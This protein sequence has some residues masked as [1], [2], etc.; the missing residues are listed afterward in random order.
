[1]RW[2]GR[3]AKFQTG[4][5][6]LTSAQVHALY[7]GFTVDWNLN[8]NI[9]TNIATDEAEKDITYTFNWDNKLREAEWPTGNSIEIK[10]D[11]LGNRVYKK[12]AVGSTVER[13][14][15]VD[16]TGKLPTI[17]LEVEPSTS[18]L[19]K[20]YIYADRQIL[21]QHDG[22]SSDDKYFYLHDRLGSVRL[23]INDSGNVVSY[24]TYEPFGEVIDDDG[25]FENAFRFTGQYFDAEI[26]EYCLRAIAKKLHNLTEDIGEKNNFGNVE[27]VVDKPCRH[28]ERIEELFRP[29]Y[30]Q[31]CTLF[32]VGFV[33]APQSSAEL[34]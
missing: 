7:Q 22:D 17:L 25:T 15:I 23:V 8:G 34:G 14:Y 26:Q 4:G 30:R 32:V 20:T 11:P 29:R 6:A 10:Y 13:K 24:Y 9:A 31:Q 19:E 1:V 16:I 5:T 33:N 27:S 3:K 21:A 2:P 28:T 18:S 12:S